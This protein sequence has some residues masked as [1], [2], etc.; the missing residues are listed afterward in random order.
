MSDG[1]VSLED[2]AHETSPYVSSG[3]H[4]WDDTLRSYLGVV[5]ERMLSAAA[6]GAGQRVLDLASGTGESAIAAAEQVGPRGSV[7]GT[8]F[9][10]ALLAIARRKA[11]RKGLKN[12]AFR[13][14]QGG[15][16]ALEVPPGPFDAVLIRWGSMFMPDPAACIAHAF[17]AL[18]KRGRIAVACWAEPHRNPWASLPLSV[19]NRYSSLPAPAPAP[20]TPD[21]FTLCDPN[22]LRTT[23]E[24]A[25]FADVRVD[26]VPVAFGEFEDA[27]EYVRMI[28]E[29][30][31]P[32]DRIFAG[33]APELRKTVIEAVCV[34]AEAYRIAGSVSFKGV[35]WVASGS[36]H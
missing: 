10:D 24:G 14:I 31:R 19:V 5:T 9:V 35:T 3:S 8:D 17:R 20:A 33:L 29:L 34:E 23:L 11:K 21:L 6:V 15:D 7:L 4:D 1:T 36:S 28:R 27:R 30:A 13:C 26:E 16:D 32:I 22:R 2:H 18:R 12:L 25:G